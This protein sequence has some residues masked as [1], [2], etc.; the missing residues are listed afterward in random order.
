M[1]EIQPKIQSKKHRHNKRQIYFETLLF[2]TGGD[3]NKRKQ[4]THQVHKIL[5]TH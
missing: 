3:V 2:G 1:I 4:P 5:C